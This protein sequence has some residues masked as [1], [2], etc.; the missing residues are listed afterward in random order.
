MSAE[1]TLRRNTGVRS[2]IHDHGP[3][4]CT[5]SSSGAGEDFALQE[6]FR[7]LQQTIVR[8]MEQQR[9]QDE[10]RWQR[11]EVLRRERETLQRTAREARK[12]VFEARMAQVRGQ[13]QVVASSLSITN[14]NAPVD[15]GA[16]VRGLGMAISVNNALTSVQSVTTVP[17]PSAAIAQPVQE[18]PSLPVRDCEDSR[19]FRLGYALKP[20]AFD[21][22]SSWEEYKIQFETIAQA[23]GWDDARK[24]TT[25]IAALKAQPERTYDTFRRAV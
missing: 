23:N 4:A 12:A 18:A 24:A 17:G 3:A 9:K 8:Q 5:R 11:G 2:G 14:S 7:S 15:Y 19:V 16:C 1:R 13:I 21:G 10:A 25:L 6:M 20:T 22:K